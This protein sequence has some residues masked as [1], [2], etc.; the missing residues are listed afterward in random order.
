MPQQERDSQS[1]CRLQCTHDVREGGVVCA[2]AGPAARRDGA[3]PRDE[4][5][6]PKRPCR[7]RQVCGRDNRH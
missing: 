4:T 5:Q 6:T 7:A 1:H 2:S 3:R